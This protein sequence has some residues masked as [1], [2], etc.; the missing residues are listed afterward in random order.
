MSDV[1]FLYI[2]EPQPIPSCDPAAYT[3]PDFGPPIVCR[4]DQVIVEP[5]YYGFG[6]CYDVCDSVYGVAT[7]CVDGCNPLC[8]CPQGYVEDSTGVCVGE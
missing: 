2:E 5:C 8:G 3:I 7:I 6:G 4:E 1:F